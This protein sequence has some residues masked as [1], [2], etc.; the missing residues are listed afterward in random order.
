MCKD[1]KAKSLYLE[2]SG[3]E[4]FK[5]LCLFWSKQILHNLVQYC[6]TPWSEDVLCYYHIKF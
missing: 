6:G 1:S 4:L 3:S 5:K 2:P